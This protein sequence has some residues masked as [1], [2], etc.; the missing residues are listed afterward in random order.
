MNIK[1]IKWEILDLM[2]DPLVSLDFVNNRHSAVVDTR[3]TDVV[4]GNLLKLVLWYDNEAGY[5]LRV[6]DQMV[7]VDS[8]I[9]NSS[10]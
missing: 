8:C 4:G 1:L 9:K 2:C 7:Y 5:S 6:L 3:W 10:K